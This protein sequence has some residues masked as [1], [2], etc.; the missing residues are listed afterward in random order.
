M[1][2][3][4]R[5]EEIEDFLSYRKRELESDIRF[6]IEQDA[7]GLL[8]QEDMIHQHATESSLL[9]VEEMGKRFFNWE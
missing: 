4:G 2:H 7:A 1:T 9:L 8:K 6:Y 3:K 5:L